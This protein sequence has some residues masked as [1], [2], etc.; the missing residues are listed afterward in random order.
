M[1]YICKNKILKNI[2][3]IFLIFL[4]T[5][6]IFPQ[7]FYWETP[8]KISNS[9]SYFLTSAGNNCIFW[10]DIEKSK[11]TN[12]GKIWI[13]G[14]IYDESTNQWKKLSKIAG[15]YL[16]TGDIPNIISAAKNKNNVIA[17][18][19]QNESNKIT[20]ITTSDNGENFVF[21]DINQNL[22]SVVA[23]KIYT[24]S[25]NGFILFATQGENDKFNLIYSISTDGK[26]WSSFKNF[27]ASANL[28]NAFVPTV[29]ADNN[30]NYVIFQASYSNGNRLSYQLYSSIGSNDGS[31]WSNAQ[32][33]TN[34]QVDNNT[35]FENYHNQRPSLHKFNNEFYVAWERS[36]FTSDSSQIYYAK[37]NSQGTL[38]GNIEAISNKG[39]ASYPTLFDYNN[40]LSAIWFDNRNGTNNIYLGQLE[41]FYWSEQNLS[42]SNN[43]NIFGLPLVTDNGKNLNIF[44][45]KTVSETESQIIHL[46]P[47]QSVLPPIVKP[48]SYVQNKA[49][50]AEKVTVKVTM[51][52][53]SSGIAGYSWC[54]TQ[55]INEE[56][57][58]VL[59]QLPSKNSITSYATKDGKWYFKV[60]AT[61]YAGNWSKSSI[62]SYEK[63]TTPPS[64]PRIILPNVDKNGYLTSNTFSILWNKPTESDVAGYSYKLEYIVQENSFVPSKPT[65]RI[66]TTK[67][68]KSWTNI[69]NGLY[70]FSVCAIDNVGNISESDSIT[71]KL[72]KYIPYTTITSILDT[73]DE[74]GNI[75]LNIY[76]KGF[77]HNGKIKN[78]YI[79]KDGKYPYDKILSLDSKE[80]KIYSDKRIQGINLEN[81]D[82]GNYKIG[83]LHSSRG[84][85]MSRTLLTVTNYGT[86]KLG[87]FS[88]I[89][90][91]T[92]SI[93]DNHPKYKVN[94]STILIIVVSFLSLLGMI[95][96]MIG[97]IKVTKDS[98]LIRQEV[99]ALITGD[100]MPT[101]KKQKSAAIKQ[102]GVSL[103][104]KLVLFITTLILMIILLV[105][106]TLG[107]FMTKNQ[108]T[109]L[110]TGLQ[111][112]LNVLM[113]S[114]ATGTKTYLPSE[115]ILQLSFLPQ[116]STSL[117]EALYT[118]IL[119]TSNNQ[120]NLNLNYVWASN[121]KNLQ[122]KIDEEN[123]TYG[124]SRLTGTVIEEITK[125][126]IT[127]NEEVIKAIGETSININ[128]LVTEAISLSL[129][130]DKKSE[131]RRNEIQYITSQLELKLNKQLND[132]SK[133]ASGSIPEFDLN[134]LNRNQT[135]YIF[136][137]P[138]L[139]R[140]G[141]EQNFVRGII[142]TEISTKSLIDKINKSTKNIIYI[143]LGVAIIALLIGIT[144]TLFL[145]SIIINP[146][147]KLVNQVNLI[148]RT[149]DKTKLSGQKI[150]IKSKDELGLLGMSVNTMTEE[151]VENETNNQF[152]LGAKDVQRA[153]IP[154]DTDKTSG[155][156]ISV[157]HMDVGKSKLFCYYQGAKGVSGD[158]FDCIKLD[159]KHY[160]IIKCDVSGKGANAAL[161]A[162]IVATLFKD[163]FKNWSFKKNKYDLSTLAYKI[164]DAVE[165]L[166]LKGKFAAYT[167]CIFNTET[168]D[169]YFC[170]AGDN[171]IN[172][173]EAKSGKKKVITLPE[174]PP[175]G[176]FPSFMIEMK[177]GYPVD[178]LHLEKDDV[179]FLFTDG[180]EEAKRLYKNDNSLS[181]RYK[182]DTNIEVTDK[183]DKNAID[184]EELTPTRVADIIESVYAK[185]K[186]ILK[187]EKNP[188]SV[189]DE[190]LVF[191]FSD[192]NSD[193]EDV[194]MA[195]VAV[196]K[197]FR[198][199]KMPNPTDFETVTIDK[200]IDAFLEKHFEQYNYFCSN[201]DVHP[202]DDYKDEYLI[203]KKLLEDEQFDDLTII[204]IKI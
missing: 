200:K 16:F 22:F 93:I 123:L 196:E 144:L 89:Y 15:P 129:K 117:E 142:I 106:S 33:I 1:K 14:T 204:A 140:H 58:S 95:F 81:L 31:T 83:L 184:G 133:Q 114:L 188:I 199:Y 178:K 32:I 124:K 80:Y 183:E 190:E 23:P 30:Q 67:E 155:A 145:S 131:E 121:D 35:K 103:R 65:A 161:I 21:T 76:G 182:P 28:T 102:K 105:A 192:C 163:Y 91:P 53:D 149:P 153:F 70:S 94:I 141:S 150:H 78:I 194:V 135:N 71:I 56:P 3:L 179:L 126:C 127:L 166:N 60:K 168:N 55:N 51:Q 52:K 152:L 170:N 20:V 202:K 88:Y 171:I 37:L 189:L 38:I 176:P 75:S 101:E 36:Y 8:Q 18:A 27:E 148:A 172:Y 74:I 73:P 138:V 41:G 90:E 57:D 69:D 6:F 136:Y 40:K 186:Y 167:L 112:R 49:S 175:A 180:I 10:Q 46:A 77:L 79:D 12:S 39:D 107:Y 104:Y 92:W 125:R 162:A 47:D 96:S 19:I 193:A 24:L 122:N 2:L 109:T 50:T 97:I 111:D 82:E 110:L 164:N 9:K 44:W 158:Y 201:K 173:Y 108:E 59:M 156:K 113:D 198:M 197:V 26:N 174:T 151:L 130:T 48:Y 54:F 134:N 195:L 63:D 42:N 66:Q 128:T 181:V 132:F 146:I 177:N 7:D 45:Q 159:E 43:S 139:Y 13:S 84:L 120:K 5:S 11:N 154:L 25:N 17:L 185:S 203:Y 187:R 100:I 115:D 68:Q 143:A 119:G 98:N 169:F 4:S 137:K 29:F 165:Q 86:V 62:V 72:N 191:N 116:Q 160:G 64:K 85:Y 99:Q 34:T 61:D 147:K 157:G 118:T 87:D